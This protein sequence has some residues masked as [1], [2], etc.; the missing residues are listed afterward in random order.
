MAKTEENPELPDADKLRLRS[1]L[2]R[3]HGAL[4]RAWLLGMFVPRDQADEQIAATIR[5]LLVMPD[6]PAEPGEATPLGV[7]LAEP[8]PPSPE[9][10]TP[11]TD[12]EYLEAFDGLVQRYLALKAGYERGMVIANT[13]EQ[14]RQLAEL[15][16]LLDD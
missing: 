3:L 13:P 6:D 2:A 15:H 4:M 11:L 1:G 8:P 7:R 16:S 14:E 10:L 12:E 5:S 9:N